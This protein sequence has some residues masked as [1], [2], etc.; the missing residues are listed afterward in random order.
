MSAAFKSRAMSAANHKPST[1]F[2][3]RAH[4]ETA[5]NITQAIQRAIEKNPAKE[6]IIKNAMECL[7]ETFY[8]GTYDHLDTLYEDMLVRQRAMEHQ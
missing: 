5:R 1:F 3:F 6:R 7:L 8:A 2:Y 4:S